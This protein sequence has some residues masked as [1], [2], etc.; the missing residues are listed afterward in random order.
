MFKRAILTVARAVRQGSQSSTAATGIAGMRAAGYA[1]RA[2]AS[3]K[4]GVSFHGLGV[5][6]LTGMAAAGSMALA[7]EACAAPNERTFIMVC[8]GAASAIVA[9][10]ND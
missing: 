9:I 10:N 6:L 1:S 2:V 5:L 8:D 7:Q 4:A 3:S